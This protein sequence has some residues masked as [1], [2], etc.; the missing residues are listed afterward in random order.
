[1]KACFWQA[2]SKSYHNTAST[3]RVAVT[4]DTYEQYYV[5]S[6]ADGGSVDEQLWCAANA[7]E[8]F[9]VW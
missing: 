1:M 2:A 8:A 4:P 6:S 7:I 3:E 5:F 9:H